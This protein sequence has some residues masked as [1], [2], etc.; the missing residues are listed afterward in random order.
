[1]YKHIVGHFRYTPTSFT[2]VT[3]LTV[4]SFLLQRTYINVDH[5]RELLTEQGTA[6]VIQ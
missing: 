3:M 1:M 5:Y 4:I 6:H 2:V